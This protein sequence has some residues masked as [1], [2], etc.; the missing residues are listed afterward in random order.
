MKKN[1][2]FTLI[3]L[4]IVVA[5]I[6]VIGAAIISIIDP[7]ESQKIA[8]DSV[9][10]SQMTNIS[11]SLEL[12][13]AQNKVYPDTPATGRTLDLS[14]FNSRIS[15]ADSTGCGIKYTKTSDGGYELISAMESK[16]FKIPEGN[17]TISIVDKP[18]DFSCTAVTKVIRLKVAQ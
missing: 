10:L 15:W 16:G 18:S 14:S 3:E 1:Y 2:G 6:A 12:S 7:F 5:I 13:F 9:R 8:R 11:S 17:S 4:I